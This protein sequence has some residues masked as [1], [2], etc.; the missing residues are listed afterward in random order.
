MIPT[1]WSS[2]NSRI[3][4]QR[5]VISF[6][7]VTSTV[8]ATRWLLSLICLA[9]VSLLDAGAHP[10]AALTLSSDQTRRTLLTAFLSSP[11]MPDCIS[12][13]GSTIDLTLNA[14]FDWVERTAGVIFFYFSRHWNTFACYHF[15]DFLILSEDVLRSKNHW[16]PLAHVSVFMMQISLCFIQVCILAST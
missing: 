7:N 4:F 13:Q 3:S 16:I 12:L 10:V 15:R 14:G 1:R 9:V 5:I 11:P 6:R 8:K 2:K